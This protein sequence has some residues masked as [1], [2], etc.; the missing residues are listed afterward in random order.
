MK[1]FLPAVFAAACSHIN[2][3]SNSQAYA[4]S[5]TSVCLSSNQTLFWDMEENILIFNAKGV[6]LGELEGGEM[7]VSIYCVKKKKGL[8]K[9][10]F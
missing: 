10:L 7:I 4:L 6:N 3:R 5:P 8:V 2:S 1:A 9:F